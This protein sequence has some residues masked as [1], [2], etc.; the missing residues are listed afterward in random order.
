MIE[1]V[2][3]LY[4]LSKDNKLLLIMHKKYGVWMPTGGH[5]EDGEETW[6]TAIREANEEAGIEVIL[7][8]F[9]IQE[10]VMSCP[11]PFAVQ[12]EKISDEHIHRDYLYAVRINKLAKHID[13]VT[14]N[15][16][17]YAWFS[18]A[19]ILGADHLWNDVKTHSLA[20]LSGV[21]RL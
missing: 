4:I 15:E 1:N 6:E 18:F 14:E 16:L 13:V 21:V 3:S 5:C 8:E 11:I 7:P 2:A 9:R 10:N 19:D 20:L 12:L 17:P